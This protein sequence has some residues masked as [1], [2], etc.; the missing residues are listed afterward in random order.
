MIKWIYAKFDEMTDG[1]T[2]DK[3]MDEYF[4]KKID[5]SFK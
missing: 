2:I 5:E 3:D 1:K 4:R